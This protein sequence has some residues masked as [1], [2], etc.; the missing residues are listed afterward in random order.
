MPPGPAVS[1]RS[2]ETNRALPVGTLLAGILLILVQLLA[3][4]VLV[5]AARVVRRLLIS[6]RIAVR[7]VVAIVLTLLIAILVSHCLTSCG[8]KAVQ[9]D[10][11]PAHEEQ[12][13]CLLRQDSTEALWRPQFTQ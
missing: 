13:T 12:V 2:S 4:A 10:A 9:R 5:S 8:L 1:L 3:I 6:F 11:D 7:I